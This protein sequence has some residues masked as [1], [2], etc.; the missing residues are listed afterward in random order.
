VKEV[1]PQE[2]SSWK[3]YLRPKY[4]TVLMNKNKLIYGL[5]YAFYYCVQFA[6]CV[7]VCNLYSDKDRLIP[8]D[9]TGDLAI[10]EKASEVFDLPFKL[11]AVFHI[12]EWLRATFLLTIICIGANLTIVWYATLP[13][14][15][16]G[17]VTYA[18]VHMS[19]FGE[20]GQLC[21]EA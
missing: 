2:N 16:F 1:L 10:P 6:G 5:N 14:T 19:Y 9:V 15:L 8:C 21:K 12:I 18:I 11:L 7:A 3:V 4:W 13:N 17:L 20:D